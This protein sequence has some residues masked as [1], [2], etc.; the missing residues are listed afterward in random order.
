MK[1]SKLSFDKITNSTPEERLEAMRI[2]SEYD[3]LGIRV[4]EFKQDNLYTKDELL[5]MS[6]IID[7]KKIPSDLESRLIERKKMMKP[8]E[9]K[10]ISLSDEEIAEFLK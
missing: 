10:S 9:S 4:D 5:A 8:V 3:R 7:N 2:H 1:H 6:L